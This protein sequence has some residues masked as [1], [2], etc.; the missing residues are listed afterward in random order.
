M[1]LQSCFTSVSFFTL[2]SLNGLRQYQ[3]NWT[4]PIHLCTNIHTLVIIYGIIRISCWLSVPILPCALSSFDSCIIHT[5]FKFQNVHFI[6]LAREN[7]FWSDQV[8]MLL[9]CTNKVATTIKSKAPHEF[10]PLQCNDNSTKKNAMI[11]TLILPYF[12][13]AWKINWN[14]HQL[15]T[16]FNQEKWGII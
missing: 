1:K 10:N 5:V 8:T 12:R 13:I 14:M 15:L 16:P 9:K 2:L 6:L 4:F 11:N 7:D 3:G